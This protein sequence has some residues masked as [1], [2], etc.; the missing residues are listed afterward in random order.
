M[1]IFFLAPTWHMPEWPAI[2]K[3]VFS[4]GSTLSVT[5]W[6]WIPLSVCCDLLRCLLEFSDIPL[7]SLL[8]KKL[9]GCASYMTMFM[10]QSKNGW[11]CFYPFPSLCL[12][13]TLR[14]TMTT[15]RNSTGC[16]FNLFAWHYSSLAALLH[17]KCISTGSLDSICTVRHKTGLLCWSPASHQALHILTI[18]R[19]TQ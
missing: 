15:A 2:Y 17:T 6:C 5:G 18:F 3:N 19:S 10:N 11:S 13:P 1:L 9:K 4:L 14:G 16:L 7:C 12:Y 8:W